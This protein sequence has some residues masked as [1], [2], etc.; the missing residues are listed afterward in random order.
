[1]LQLG[2][3][4]AVIIL[5]TM[6][7]RGGTIS[8]FQE[9]QSVMKVLIIILLV[10]FTLPAE[11]TIIVA[12]EIWAP[13]RIKMNEESFSGIDIDILNR[14]GD[15]MGIVFRVEQYPWVRCL[16]NMKQGSVDIMTGLAYTDER[17]EYIS[18]SNDYYYQCNAAFYTLA[19]DT[20]RITQYDDLKGLEIGYTR[21]SAYFE[22]FN[23]DTT[24]IKKDFH[25]E[26]NLLK[27]LLSRRVDTF[28]G[29][30]CQV[31]YDIVRMGYGEE[32]VQQE[33]IPEDHI[34]LY[35]GVS[36]RSP[37]VKRWEE[38][39]SILGRLISEGVVDSTAGK[40]FQ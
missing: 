26:A 13:F 17:A 27:L 31:A 35:I 15:E 2:V 40:Y 20:V 38:F 25:G 3:L 5:L 33:Y 12:T 4:R 37:F 30:D 23:S 39:N 11:D 19:A 28:V 36:Q 10:L 24:L 14:I 9:R 32:I 1:M 18:Y 29:T 34:R 7:K 6:P 16:N 8:P 21:G 22:P